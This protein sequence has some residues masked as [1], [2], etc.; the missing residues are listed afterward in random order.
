M[1]KCAFV[2]GEKTYLR[3]LRQEDLTVD[4]LSWLND[5]EVLEFSSRKSFP[6]GMEQ[7]QKY[8]ENLQSNP[9]LFLA[10][11]MKDSDKHVGNM[12][13]NTIFWLHRSAE[14]SIVVGDKSVW[15]KG[16]AS[17]AIQA[18]C[19]HGFMTMNL[20]RIWAE[21]PNPAF[22]RAVNKLGWTHEGLRREAF[23]YKGEFIDFECT[24]ILAPEWIKLFGDKSTLRKR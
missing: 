15:G 8:Y 11:C 4:Y 5:P 24:S 2:I 7:L 13:L 6:T 20:H 23:F 1:N 12:S 17:D 18:L 19:R 9:D 3:K 10:I 22:N 21:S 14:L 16:V